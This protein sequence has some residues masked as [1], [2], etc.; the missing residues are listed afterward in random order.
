[1][2]NILSICD[3]CEKEKKVKIAIPVVCY[4]P[5]VFPNELAGLPLERQVK[6]KIDLMPGTTP[7]AKAPYYLAPT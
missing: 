3:R 7:I 6:F 4:F 5:E 1:M 2:C